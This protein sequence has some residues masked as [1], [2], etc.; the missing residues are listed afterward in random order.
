MSQAAA[1]KPKDLRLIK[2]RLEEKLFGPFQLVT[3]Q[4]ISDYLYVLRAERSS[5]TS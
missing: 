3:R 1:P 4:D 2:E 5:K